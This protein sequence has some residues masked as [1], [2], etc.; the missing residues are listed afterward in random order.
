M[1][2]CI[3][4]NV[5][6]DCVACDNGN[7]VKDDLTCPDGADSDEECE[8]RGCRICET[9]AG[10]ETCLQCEPGHAVY[11]YYDDDGNYQEKCIS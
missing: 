10:K 11:S 9:M 2:N 8:I 3:K 7:R 1:E 5:N 4:L 6:G